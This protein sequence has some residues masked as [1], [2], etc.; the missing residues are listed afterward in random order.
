MHLVHTAVLSEQGNEADIMTPLHRMS[1]RDLKGNRTGLPHLDV[2][3]G[4]HMATERAAGC[5]IR[6]LNP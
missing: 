6:P 2:S 1:T 3:K 4:I 5:S